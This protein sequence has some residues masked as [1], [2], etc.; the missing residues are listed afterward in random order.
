MYAGD[1]RGHMWKF[2][3]SSSSPGA[4]SVAFGGSP[5]TIDAG[6]IDGRLFFAPPAVDALAA[7]LR[8]CLEQADRPA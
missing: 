2:D 3:L 1:L 4:W 7:E 5:R 8:A 6:Q